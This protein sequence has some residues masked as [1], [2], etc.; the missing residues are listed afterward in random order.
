MEKIKKRNEYNQSV[1]NQIAKKHGITKD[2]VRKCLGG[3]RDNATA[4]A[5]KKDYYKTVKALQEAEKLVLNN[6][7]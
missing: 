3:V 2:Y 7:I 5:I 6:I 4:D 1:V